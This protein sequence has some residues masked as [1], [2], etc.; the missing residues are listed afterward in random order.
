MRRLFVETPLPFEEAAR[1]ATDDELTTARSFAVARGRE[2]L[3]WRAIVRRELGRDTAIAYDSV[4]APILT[5]R[6]LRISVSHCRGR[7]A[8]GISDRPCAVDI[9]RIDRD[10]TRALSRYLSPEERRISSHPLFPAVAWCAKEVL[11]KYARR[12]ELDLLQD[13]HID[14][15]S[16]PESSV[17]N[18]ESLP[19]DLAGRPCGT[20]HA[21][22]T[23]VSD[24]LSPTAVP[25]CSYSPDEAAPRNRILRFYQEND[26]IVVFLFD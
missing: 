12:Q 17:P 10:F 16:F 7:I 19:E 22:Y 15:I 23:K 21:H 24:E 13:L 2:Y 8:V 3:G 1:W 9:E 11:Y 5:N 25:A 6:P 4:G 26:C 14:R 18:D 20:I